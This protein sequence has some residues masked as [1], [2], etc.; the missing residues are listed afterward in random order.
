LNREKK[1][2]EE[3]IQGYQIQLILFYEGNPEPSK[4]AHTEKAEGALTG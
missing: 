1:N 2:Q 3:R 4:N